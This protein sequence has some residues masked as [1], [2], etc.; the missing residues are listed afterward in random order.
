MAVDAFT[1]AMFGFAYEPEMGYLEAYSF[2]LN[3][4]SITKDG[5]RSHNEII[6]H[7]SCWVSL[8]R[9]S[10]DIG[11]LVLHLTHFYVPKIPI[12]SIHCTIVGSQSSG[13]YE[14]ILGFRHNRP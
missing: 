11:V 8:E 5:L 14:C 13:K 4:L 1:W 3:R 12:P 9:L 2:G 7:D 10:N 6:I